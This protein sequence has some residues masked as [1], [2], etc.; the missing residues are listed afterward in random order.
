MEDSASVSLRGA[1]MVWSL[2][3]VLRV[4]FRRRIRKPV[5]GAVYRYKK[6]IWY[7]IPR[8]A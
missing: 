3:F 6:D 5:P 1:D 4:V 7:H 8:S 2:S